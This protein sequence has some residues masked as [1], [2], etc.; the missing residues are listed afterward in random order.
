MESESKVIGRAVNKV[1]GKRSS[2]GGGR[3]V[4]RRE[5]PPSSGEKEECGSPKLVSPDGGTEVVPK[6]EIAAKR[7]KLDTDAAETESKVTLRS[8][9][10]R[11]MAVFNE[12][13]IDNKE[14]KLVK[15]GVKD[16]EEEDRKDGVKVEIDTKKEAE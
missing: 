13:D 16:G 15:V 10:T 2:S 9:R 5:L 11:S 6:T 14:G 12:E 8:M 3:S 7:V 1:Y 4:R